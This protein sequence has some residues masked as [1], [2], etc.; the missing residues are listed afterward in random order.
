MNLSSGGGGGG[1]FGLL[2]LME[3]EEKRRQRLRGHCSGRRIDPRNLWRQLIIAE[4]SYS[5]GVNQTG[6]SPDQVS[7]QKQELVEAVDDVVVVA[8]GNGDG[9]RVVA[10]V[11]R[12]NISKMLT[13]GGNEGERKRE[14]EK[15]L[16][17]V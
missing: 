5:R 13:E 12:G 9:R 15:I 11:K 7:G 16:S 4:I 2:G 17:D 14:R 10:A 8:G 6:V 3:V 1:G